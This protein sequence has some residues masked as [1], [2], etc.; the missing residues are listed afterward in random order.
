MTPR[1]KEKYTKEIIPTMMKEFSYGNI[2]E[3]PKVQKIVLNVG[4]GEAIQNIKLLEAAQRELATIT[5]QKPIVCKAKKS[6]ATFKLRQGMV[7]GCRVTL[8]GN[9]MYEFL[10]RLITL[11]IPLRKF[12]GLEDFITMRHLDNMAKIMLG[13]RLTGGVFMTGGFFLGPN[14]FYERLRTMPPQ[15]LAKIDMTRIDFIN[16]LYGDDALKR[17]KAAGALTIAVVGVLVVGLTRWLGG[18][19]SRLPRAHTGTAFSCSD[20]CSACHPCAGTARRSPRTP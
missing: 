18:A 5:G 1:L 13:T 8:R 9:R 12:Y 20:N 2:M 11:A 19:R 17:A 7:V 6:I 16:Q 10:D 3:V 15:E 14:D 4:L